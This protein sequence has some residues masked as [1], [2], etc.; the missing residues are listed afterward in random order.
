MADPASENRHATPV[1][2][3]LGLARPPAIYL[4]AIAAGLLLHFARPIPF[5]PGLAKP[6]GAII[7]IGAAALS[8]WSV[9]TFRSAGTPVPGNRPTAAIVKSGPYRFSRN[10]IYLAF[11]LFQTGIA[12]MVND[13]WILVTLLA[14]VSVIS[15]VVIPR[16]ERYL[17]ARFGKEYGTYKAGVRRWL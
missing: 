8:V 12:L 6:L 14:A 17:Q 1:A 2:A 15:F 9:R 11:S 10:P 16:E 5:A 3:N 13:A 4:I 7:A